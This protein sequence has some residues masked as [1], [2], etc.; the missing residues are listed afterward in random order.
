MVWVEYTHQINLL[1][2]QARP[3]KDHLYVPEIH[4]I[5]GVEFCECKDDGHLF[6]VAT[7]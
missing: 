2:S 7:W 1:H 3:F 4:L 5:T 6:Q